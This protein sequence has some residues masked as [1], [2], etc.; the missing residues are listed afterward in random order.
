MRTLIS[1][2]TMDHAKNGALHD[3]I[4]T[5]SWL[6]NE[7]NKENMQS[8][9]KTRLLSENSIVI[10]LLSFL[11]FPSNN[12]YTLKQ[13]KK[14][15]FNFVKA[16][17]IINWGKLEQVHTSENHKIFGCTYSTFDSVMDLETN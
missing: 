4:E 3:L 6:L 5:I 14:V 17:L 10:D 16:S 2:V 7:T 12:N 8:M 1:A 15:S 11:V 9:F 13:N